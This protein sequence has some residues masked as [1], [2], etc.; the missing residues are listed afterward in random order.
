M[1]DIKININGWVANEPTKG[2][3]KNG[4]NYVNF[5]IATT[6]RFKADNGEWQDGKTE[7]INAVSY[8]EPLVTNIEQSIKKGDPV[9][10]NGSLSTNEFVRQ[11]ESI[12]KS[13]ELKI[14]SIGH[15]LRLGSSKF[16]R[17][18]YVIDSDKGV[19]TTQAEN[20]TDVYE[21]NKTT[22]N[23]ASQTS[24]STKNTS[25]LNNNSASI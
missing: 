13:L 3:S 20:T 21:A 15:D 10:V 18:K 6:P 22:D 11:D 7:W 12:G 8:K 16:E 14:D 23:S 4:T 5:R 25:A 19:V 1:N 2:V 24:D 9:F 17:I